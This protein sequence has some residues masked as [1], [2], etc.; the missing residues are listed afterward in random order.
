METR[1]KSQLRSYVKSIDPND[2]LCDNCKV[3]GACC[4]GAFKSEDGKIYGLRSAKCKLLGK[5]GRCGDYDNRYSR[6]SGCL[7][8][9]D[10]I[11]QKA[12]PNECEYVKGIDGYEGK[13]VAD[14]SKEKKL[15][16]EM[17]KSMTTIPEY[18]SEDLKIFLS[19]YAQNV[20]VKKRGYYV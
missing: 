6:V 3:K 19:E 1:L 9:V 8:I 18:C 4:Y 5:D 7:P 2:N 20:N 14:K 10:A 11:I 12:V 17:A 13:I 15:L 16:K